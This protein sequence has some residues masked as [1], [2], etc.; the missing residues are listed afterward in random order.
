[1]VA[2]FR[3]GR[4]S[5]FVQ[6]RGSVPTCWSQQ[7]TH[8]ITKPKPQISIDLKD[9]FYEAAGKHFNNL[10]FDYGSPVIVLN[11]VKRKEKRPQEGILFDEFKTAIEYLNQFIPSAHQI[12]LIGFDMARTNKIK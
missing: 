1:N 7:A 10:L 5:S 9:P 3:I 2:S 11:L 8:K 6:M 4:F 12:Q